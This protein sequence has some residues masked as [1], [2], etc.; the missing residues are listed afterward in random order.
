MQPM[1]H[2]RKG[3]F[4]LIELLV[5]IAIVAILALIVLGAFG[6]SRNKATDT[7]IISS[8]RQLRVIAEDYYNAN[9]LEYDGFENCVATPTT[10]LCLED[11]I[12]ANVLTLKGE[13]AA[14]NGQLIDQAVSVSVDEINKRFCLSAPLKSDPNT[15]VCAESTGQI[16]VQGSASS[17]CEDVTN[18]GVCNFL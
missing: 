3:G 7:R 9:T 6:L 10:Q 17:P 16:N 18:P 1:K 13:I 15:Y 5:V 8:V 2:V 14:A 4:T 12:R 11:P